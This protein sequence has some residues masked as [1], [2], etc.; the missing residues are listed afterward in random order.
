MTIIEFAKHVDILKYLSDNQISFL[1]T[2]YKSGEKTPIPTYSLGRTRKTL[3]YNLISMYDGYLIAKSEEN[4]KHVIK[5]KPPHSSL[6]DY[7]ACPNCGILLDDEHLGKI[8]Y[9]YECGQ[10]LI[11]EEGETK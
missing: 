9:C 7:I 5:V 3:M 10:K 11:W 4:A 6:Y 2:M 1:E 8:K